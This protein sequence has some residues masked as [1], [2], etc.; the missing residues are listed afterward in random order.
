MKKIS[1]VFSLAS[2]Y[3]LIPLSRDIRLISRKIMEGAEEPRSNPATSIQGANGSDPQE[4]QSVIIV[5]EERCYRKRK[6]PHIS[7]EER[8]LDADTDPLIK[9]GD[10]LLSTLKD[11]HE[12]E[13]AFLFKNRGG[14]ITCMLR[15]TSEASDELM[16]FDLVLI[17]D[18]VK[19]IHDAFKTI[20]DMEYTVIAD[21][22]GDY[23]IDT[24]TVSR[25]ASPED[26]SDAV[27]S[28]NSL[29]EMSICECYEHLI[30]SPYLGLCYV[31][32]ISKPRQD[33]TGESCIICTEAIHTERGIRRMKCCNQSMHK[34]CYERWRSEEENRLCP[35]CRK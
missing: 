14:D 1:N 16:T 13:E 29:Y 23:I 5:T 28:I 4:G 26:M 32:S 10:M 25:D 9:S 12:R 24:I 34:K 2:E 6:R 19:D 20:M 22:E 7:T 11:M 21:E 31:C 17:H 35:I 27:E 30:K 15:S 33:D 18:P 3:I 8:L